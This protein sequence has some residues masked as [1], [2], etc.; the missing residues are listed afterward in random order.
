MRRLIVLRPRL[1]RRLSN[2]KLRANNLA[3]NG[4]R[5]PNDDHDRAPLVSLR[6]HTNTHTHTGAAV[7]R[8]QIEIGMQAAFACSSESR[9]VPAAIVGAAVSGT[10]NSR[11]DTLMPKHTNIQVAGRAPACRR[12]IPLRASLPPP[13]GWA[14]DAINGVRLAKSPCRRFCQPLSLQICC[15]ECSY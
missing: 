12:H 13:M 5:A 10:E 14:A 9:L 4:E 11:A 8:Q 15:P 3:N 7:P 6:W 2:C 1:R